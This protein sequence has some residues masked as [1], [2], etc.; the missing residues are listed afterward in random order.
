MSTHANIN[1]LPDDILIRILW[2]SNPPNSYK[3]DSDA[4][5]HT[6]G[7]TPDYIRA[8]LSVRKLIPTD[9]KTPISTPPG[10]ADAALSLF[11]ASVC[12]RWRRLVQ[13]HVSTLLVRENRLVPLQALTHAVSCLP[14]L[15]HLHLCDGS[16]ETLDDAFLAHLASSCPKLTILHVGSGIAPVDN[17]Y[18]GREDDHP[19][20]EAGLD[21]F[22]RQCTQLQQLSLFCL[23]E[24]ISL[25]ASFFQLADLHTLALTD[26]SALEAPDLLNLS[27]L[28]TL[29][30]SSQEITCE[31]IGRLVRLTRLSN[32]SIS[33][34]TCLYPDDDHSAALAISTIAR[35]PCLKS[36]EFLL[37]FRSEASC[38]T[39]EQLHITDT[40]Q[41]DRLPDD[42]GALLPCLRELT[43]SSCE[44]LARLP[45]NFSS[46]SCL[47]SLTISKCDHFS[48]LPEKIGSLPALKRLVLEKLPLSDLPDS[49]CELSSLES[50]FLIGCPEIHHLPAGFSRL[51]GLRTLSLMH[52]PVLT[53]PE[54]IGGLKSLHTFLLKENY[55]QLLPASFSQLTS[56]V[57]VELDACIIGALPEGMQQMSHLLELHIG[58]CPN[59]T[60]IPE[61]FSRLP[62]LQVLTVN[63]CT[64]L[65]SVP[66]RLDSLTKLKRLE[67]TG[68]RQLTELP[69]ILPPSLEILHLGCYNQVSKLPRTLFLPSLTSLRLIS[70]GVEQQGEESDL[71]LPHLNCLELVLA[72]DAE[73]LP[74]PLA[75]L[76][77]LRTLGIW[78]AGKLKQLPGNIGLVLRQLRKLQIHHAHELAE[79]PAS[80]SELRKLTSMEI[81][82]APKLSTLPDAISALSRLCKLNLTHCPALKLLPA[83]LTQ[84]S[85]LYDLSIQFASICWLPADFANLKRLRGLSVHGI[86][87]CLCF[88]LRNFRIC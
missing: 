53:L 3:S 47:E 4:L 26:A 60:E 88:C 11:I 61:S 41:L 63:D 68:C 75:S 22:F 57:Q 81:L 35:L 65:S 25:P 34:Q 62:G 73:E 9:E 82:E 37:M 16:V 14:N 30:I 40:H 56:L 24:D 36:L 29:T 32:L 6:V 78:S 20:T 1:Q 83:S 12:P 17:D 55:G 13:R 67:L 15:T 85:C 46:L 42:I 58:A 54:G 49:L 21:H 39:L 28:T 8:G 74:F 43:L 45:R 48:R 52:L 19:I 31:Q 50:L 66:R 5:W 18:N 51:T 80:I 27:S 59:I 44:P 69:E 7:P 38:T 10:F 84:L 79:L 76:S 87:T 71:S 33:D 23:H 2:H 86:C 77:Q 64:G 72:D 70:V